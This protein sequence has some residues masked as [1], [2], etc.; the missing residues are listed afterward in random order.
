MRR[1]ADF[2]HGIPC[3]RWLRTLVNRIVNKPY[4]SLGPLAW[5]ALKGSVFFIGAS[6][7]K[8]LEYWIGYS[9]GPGGLLLI[10]G[11]FVLGRSRSGSPGIEA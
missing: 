9:L 4:T 7:L 6:P 11:A 3:A 2:H 8:E 1:F 5:P 10:L